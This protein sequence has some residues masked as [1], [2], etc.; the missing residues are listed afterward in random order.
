M[1]V[2]APAITVGVPIMVLALGLCDGVSSTAGPGGCICIMTRPNAMAL[3]HP[4]V[5]GSWTVVMVLVMV[6]STLEQKGV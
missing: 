6:S 2:V 4:S 5:N 3:L 1:W